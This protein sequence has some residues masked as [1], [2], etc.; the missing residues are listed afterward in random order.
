MKE[1]WKLQVGSITCSAVEAAFS[2][3]EPHE[4]MDENHELLE[5]KQG[6]VAV[7]THPNCFAAMRQ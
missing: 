6:F 4:I 1:A 5:L 7:K 2:E 3:L